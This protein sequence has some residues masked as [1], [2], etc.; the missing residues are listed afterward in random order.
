VAFYGKKEGKKPRA[1]LG[2]VAAHE[3]PFEEWFSE[4]ILSDAVRKAVPVNLHPNFRLIH[5]KYGLE[6]GESLLYALPCLHQLP[7]GELEVKGWQL[8]PD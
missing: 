6:L 2:L 3:Q 1:Y 4:T 8:L 7:I 5:K